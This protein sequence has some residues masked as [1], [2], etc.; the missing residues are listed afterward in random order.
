MFFKSFGSIN[1]S[2]TSVFFHKPL[3]AGNSES[4]AWQLTVRSCAQSIE[5]ETR[6]ASQL[7]MHKIQIFKLTSRRLPRRLIR[8]KVVLYNFGFNWPW[9]YT[10]LRR[11]LNQICQLKISGTLNRKSDV[12]PSVS[13]KYFI[14]EWVK[15]ENFPKFLSGN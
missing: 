7:Q 1:T 4:H 8:P 14:L 3:L 9:T 10:F 6:A 5:H 2:E 15:T 11:N 12:L 13:S